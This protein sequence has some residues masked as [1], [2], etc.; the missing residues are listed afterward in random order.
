MMLN[1]NKYK[2]YYTGSVV[3]TILSVIAL[4]SSGICTRTLFSLANSIDTDGA[5]IAVSASFVVFALFMTFCISAIALSMLGAGFALPSIKGNYLKKVNTAILICN[6]VCFVT[7][8]VLLILILTDQSL[9]IPP[10]V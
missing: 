10:Y 9:M 2:K 5:L 7:G 8:T 1:P 6:I 4:I 3:Y